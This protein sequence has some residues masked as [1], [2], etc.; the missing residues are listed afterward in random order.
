MGNGRNRGIPRDPGGRHIR[1]YVTLLNCPAYRVLGDAAKVLFFDLREK[2]NASNNGNIEATLSMLKH[3]GWTSST[4]LAKALY[5]LRALGFIAVTRGGGV[6]H[7]SRVCSLYGFTDLPIFEYPKLGIPASPATNAYLRF[8]SVN[9]AEVA[10]RNGVQDLRKM[11]VERK[12]KAAGRKK[13]TLQNL[14]PTAPDSKAVGGIHRSRKWS[15]DQLTAPESGA[16]KPT[17]EGREPA[18]SK[19]LRQITAEHDSNAVCSRICTPL[20]VATPREQSKGTTPAVDPAAR[21]EKAVARIEKSSAADRAPK[22]PT[23]RHAGCS[24]LV[25]IGRN[26]CG[27][28][29]QQL[30][31][32][33]GIPEEMPRC[34]V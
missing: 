16:E 20:Y 29:R 32:P 18:P 5:E 12:Q 23:C 27:K 1:V 7:G 14:H 2:V 33:A 22:P 8:Q 6:E 3:K 34:V 13:T 4:T 24:T 17:E 21:I 31:Q 15:R 10:L 19:D 9:E 26:F 11:A 25:L 30:E 28:H